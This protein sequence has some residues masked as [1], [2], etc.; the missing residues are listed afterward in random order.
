MNLDFGIGPYD[1]CPCGSGEKYKFCCAAKASRHGKYPIG[2]VAFYGPDDKTMTKIAAGAIL[3]DGD[4]PILR[5]W[6]GTDIVGNPKIADEIKRFF[7]QH[8][9]K[10][11]VVTQGNLGCPHEEGIDFPVG[12]DCPFCPFWAGKQGSTRRPDDEAEDS[13]P[14]DEQ[15]D[16][17]YEEDE[18]DDDSHAAVNAE[19]QFARMEAVLG[20]G[21]MDFERAIDILFAHIQSNLS[22]PCEVTGSEPF[23]WEEPYLLGGWS[24]AEYKRL[25]KTQP[26]YTDR[27]QLLGIERNHYSQWMTLS[28]DIAAHVQR[29]SDGKQFILGLTDLEATD[30][31]SANF[32]LLDDY[33]VWF[34]NSR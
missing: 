32:Q 5:R 23:H 15:F 20:D 26:S 17:E 27:Y 28:E 30:K 29:I 6:V 12:Q 3:R 34:V 13:P 22:L 31:N 16:D 18:A 24:P 25:K 33:V 2:T 8:G 11:I 10:N 19:A 9:V 7:A 4:E 1:P 14:D 21:K